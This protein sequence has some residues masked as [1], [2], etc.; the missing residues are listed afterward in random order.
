MLGTMAGY[1]GIYYPRIDRTNPDAAVQVTEEYFYLC[2]S[3]CRS[4]VQMLS[5]L[6]S[7]KAA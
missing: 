6:N 7:H 2:K 4:T 1:S 5:Y 3:A